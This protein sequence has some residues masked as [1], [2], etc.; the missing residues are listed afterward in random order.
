[1]L[2]AF[3]ARRD[4][5]VAGLKEIPGV[6]CRLPQGAFYAFPNV[7]RLGLT[8]R[9]CADRMLEEAGI[10]CLPGT[11]FGPM[12]E[13]HLRLSYATSLPNIEDALSRMRRW[14]EESLAAVAS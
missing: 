12:G 13:G 11:S 10:A 8:A 14:V 3:R 2:R 6:S 5:I 9:A 1:M 7:R 4:R